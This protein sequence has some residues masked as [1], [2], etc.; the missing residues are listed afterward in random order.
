MA[1]LK[2][3]NNNNKFIFKP[4][5]YEVKEELWFSSEISL[6]TSKKILTKG[7]R[8]FHIGDFQLLI[9]GIRSLINDKEDK[10][11]FD[12]IEPYL[13]IVMEKGENNLILEID[14]CKGPI[15]E[16]S[17]HTKMKIITSKDNLSYF[18]GQFIKELEQVDSNIDLEKSYQL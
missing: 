1:E 13:K 18:I 7:I 9:Y 14:F 5:N 8:A 6:K 3:I 16:Q 15:F 17:Q 11:I 4:F 2:D 12:P 10:F